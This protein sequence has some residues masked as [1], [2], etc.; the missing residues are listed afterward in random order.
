MKN[1]M[2][3]FLVFTGI[4]AV[5][6]GAIFWGAWALNLAPVAP[7]CPTVYPVNDAAAWWQGVLAGG[8]FIPSDLM[9]VLGGM[10]FWQEL[11]FA[12]A[13]WLAALGIAYY[14]RGR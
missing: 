10:Y 7:D 5:A 11:Q 8:S 14:L 13:A 12:L 4:Y 6:M 2:F 9:H 1:K 3:G